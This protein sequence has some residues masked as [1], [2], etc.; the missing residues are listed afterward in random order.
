MGNSCRYCP[1]FAKIGTRSQ[2]A[3]L[4]KNPPANAGSLSSI[5]GLGRSLKRGE[6]LP[7]PVFLPGEFHGLRSLLYYSSW[8]CKESNMIEQLTLEHSGHTQV[9]TRT[10]TGLPWEERW[11]QDLNLSLDLSGDRWPLHQCSTYHEAG[12]N[13]CSAL[14]SNTRASKAP[15]LPLS[16][17][18]ERG[19]RARMVE[20]CAGVHSKQDKWEPR[21]LGWKVP[22]CC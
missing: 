9:N 4:V 6:W 7:T 14:K 1:V 13:I 5:P 18:T 15:H 10:Y 8:G 21:L 16:L 17:Q 19:G 3:Q 20:V 22:R 12:F 11:S 2:E